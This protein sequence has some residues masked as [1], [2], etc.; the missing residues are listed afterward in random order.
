MV[1][2]QQLC[3]IVCSRINESVNA[4]DG[5]NRAFKHNSLVEIKQVVGTMNI[6]YV[7]P[8]LI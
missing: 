5:L 7:N 8:Q 2:K 4:G 1:I 3:G 6:V